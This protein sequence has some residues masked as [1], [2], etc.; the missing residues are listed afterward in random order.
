[1]TKSKLT[2][3]E[4]DIIIKELET[5]LITLDGM[6]GEQ[7]AQ[8]TK[9]ILDN[10]EFVTKQHE[11]IELLNNQNR[12]LKAVNWLVTALFGISLGINIW[13]FWL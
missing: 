13:V 12:G 9:H 4:K 11:L 6:Y 3:A 7:V 1:M 2:H 8:Y 5:N 10:T